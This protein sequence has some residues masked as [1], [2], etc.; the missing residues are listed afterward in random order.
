[1]TSLPVIAGTVLEEY[2]DRFP[3][4]AT[5]LGDHTHDH[6]LDDPSAAA[7]DARAVQIR[8][9]LAALAALSPEDDTVDAAVL[10][11][12]LSA[13][14]LD[15][16]DLRED[17]WNPMR[18][19]PGRSVHALLSRDFAP[20][21]DRVRAATQRVAGV[22]AHLAAAR[23]RLEDMSAVHLRTAL[24]QLDGSLALLDDELPA[25]AARAG[26]PAPDTAA[27]HEAVVA[28]QQWLAARADAAERS[29]RIGPDLFRSKL[30]LTLDTAY[31]PEHLLQQAENDLA[32]VL[33]A[34]RA[35]AGRIA[36]FAAPDDDTVREVL[37][38]LGA[39]TPTDATILPM[40][41]SSLAEATAF[42]RDRALVTVHDDPIAVVPMPEIDRGVAAAY[43]RQNG[44]LEQ[45][46]LPTEYAVSPTPRE[47]D[48]E[49][50]ASFYREYNAHMI[51]NLT[52][53]EAMPGHAL[54]LMHANR[55][56][57]E[58]PV[59]AVWWSGTFVEGWAVY[60]EELMAEHGF[61]G[62][63]VRMQQLKMALRMILNTILD[64][65]FHCDD[66]DERAAIDLMTGKG[67]QEAGEAAGK[68]RRVQLTSAQL[69]TYYVGYH[70]VRAV[71]DDLRTA[72]PGWDD[73]T[74]HD[75]MLAHGSPP[76]R[77]LRTLLDLAPA[78]H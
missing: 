18:H 59:R 46:V 49:R 28:H 4:E 55:Y 26:L 60:A 42:V 9:S 45:A 21:A 58:T 24:T 48:A 76:A 1:M 74:R 77:H 36:G 39:D 5:Y 65:R 67:F 43:C 22:P 12:V 40:C 20:L 75:A 35:E 23:E 11:T 70:E 52:V 68:W 72:H 6:L 27:A 37:A 57:G 8:T 73:R 2:L 44:P 71:A 30:A 38:R 47:W 66:L 31:E 7:A 15:L 25:A 53:H 69:C 78:S 41:R 61:G 13:E 64:I 29:P 34:I 17:E 56:R 16:D 10:R 51:A 19:N 50:T 3:T 33:A 63:S 62:P 14:L 32:T 54:Q